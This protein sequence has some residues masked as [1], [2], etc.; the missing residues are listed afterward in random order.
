MRVV[1][2]IDVERGVHH[3]VRVIRRRVPDH[4]DFVTELGG[5]ADGR[6][7]AGVSYQAN[8]DQPMDAVLL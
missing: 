6:F 3:F 1:R 8:Y 4:G 5:V 2:D 7:D